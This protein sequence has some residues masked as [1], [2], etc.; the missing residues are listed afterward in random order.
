M[1]LRT[2]RLLLCGEGL[3]ILFS[4]VVADGA[5]DGVGGG[6]D[7]ADGVQEL[8]G[9]DLAEHADAADGVAYL[10]RHIV[11]GLSLIHI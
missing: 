1:G 3:F 10:A 2:P 7:E 11:D 4:P 6:A 9:L 5:G 8:V